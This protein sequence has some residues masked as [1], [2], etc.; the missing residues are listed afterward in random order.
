MLKNKYKWHCKST[1]KDVSC[2]IGRISIALPNGL[3]VVKVLAELK[4]LTALQG[5]QSEGHC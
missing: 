1:I 3:I 4:V 2:E 5:Y